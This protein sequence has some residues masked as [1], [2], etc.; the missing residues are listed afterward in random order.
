MKKYILLSLILLA[1][2][3]CRKEDNIGIQMS[4]FPGVTEE[5]G[6]DEPRSAFN[7]EKSLLR[8]VVPGSAG[9]PEYVD[10]FSAINALSAENSKYTA[11]VYFGAVN[12]DGKVLVPS[13]NVS[14][15]VDPDVD[16]LCSLAVNEGNGMDF[17]EYK[18]C[19][20]IAVSDKGDFFTIDQFVES[21][22]LGTMNGLVKWMNS[23][24]E[25]ENL[26][27]GGSS[28]AEAIFGA[29][30]GGYTFKFTMPDRAVAAVACSKKDYLHGTGSVDVNWSVTPVHS[31][32]DQENGRGD[33]YIV[34][35]SVAFNSSGMWTGNFTSMHGGVHVRICGA[36]AREFSIKTYIADMDGKAVGRY[37][38]GGTPRPTTSTGSTTYSKGYTWNLG[39]SL[40]G[41]FSQTSG[42]NCGLT[43]NGGISANK[44][45]S[46]SISDLDIIL[47]QK[48]PVAS[49]TLV[50]NNLPHY[51]S[52]HIT[53]A[54]PICRS[55]ATLDFSYIV[56]LPDVR[57]YSTDRHRMAVQITE[58]DYGACRFYSTKADY[59]DFTWGLEYFKTSTSSY[60]KEG[61][62]LPLPNRIPTGSLKITHDET[63]YGK[64]IFEIKAISVKNPK[65][66]YNFTGSSYSKGKSFEANLPTG[67]YD[68]EMKVGDSQSSTV[69]LKSDLQVGIKRGEQTGLNTGGDFVK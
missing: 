14:I 42:F 2:L 49:Y 51:T 18:E 24:A 40:T 56:H 30:H 16:A 6:K 61:D 64:Y 63:T 32:D 27:A 45:E 60:R 36:F 46:R 11:T 41:G 7:Q 58:L 48:E 57:D 1:V 37:V 47:N 52:I 15:I 25:R 22:I 5:I 23:Y 68:I 55:T 21:D 43:L 65:D 13:G 9:N 44:S 67:D 28:D 69:I 8:L 3:S 35:G 12:G 17:S 29:I 54:P 20:L 62:V 39:S 53:D 10:A 4:S 33:Y 66:V 19:A 26:I 50:F 31:F 34:N 59:R 38:A